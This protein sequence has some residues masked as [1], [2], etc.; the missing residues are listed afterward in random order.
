MNTEDRLLTCL[1]FP[2]EQAEAAATHY[3][4]TF[5]PFRRDTA[6]GTVTRAPLDL[7]DRDG[8]FRAEIRQEG[9]DVHVEQGRVL[10]VE[11]TLD[12]RPF[13]AMDDNRSGRTFTDAT[14]FQVICEDQAEVDHFWDRL[15]AGG[16]EVMCGWLKDR[17]GVSW[18]VVPRLLMQLMS[19]ADREAAGRV[20]RQMMSMVKLD[21][22]PL[23]TA[24]RG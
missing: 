9:D 14:S 2:G 6:L 19:G 8:E 10:M 13:I 1:W 11:F 22:A 7:V 5:A 20:Q 15:T 17:F 16:E 24:A 23:E 4:D 3:V 12:G 18:Q 21:L